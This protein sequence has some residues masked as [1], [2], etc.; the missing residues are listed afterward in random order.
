MTIPQDP[1]SP[2]QPTPP[3]GLLDEPVLVMQQISSMMS[4][5]FD[6]SNGD[7]ERVGY[8]ETVGS[9]ARRMVMGSRSLIVH[10]ADGTEV[11]T[12]EDPVNFVRDTYTLA[13]PDGKSLAD[14]SKRFSLFRTQVDMHLVDGTVVELH[15]NVFDFNFEFRMGEATPASVTR[16]WSGIGNAFLGRSTYA[17]VFDPDASNTVR[18]AI[19]GGVVALDLIRRKE[20]ES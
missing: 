9:A 18:A 16:Q 19:I 2:H 14:V 13:T 8:I 6:I 7:G 3:S 20:D 1:S 15:G 12:V 4:N 5:N 11:V 10:E 17:V